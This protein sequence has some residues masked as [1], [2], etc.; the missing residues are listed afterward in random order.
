MLCSVTLNLDSLCSVDIEGRERRE[1]GRSGGVE[2]GVAR[3]VRGGS[4]RQP[5]S[6]R[7]MDHHIFLKWSD[8]PPPY[9]MATVSNTHQKEVRMHRFSARFCWS[10]QPSLQLLGSW[11]S[12]AEATSCRS[13]VTQTAHIA[14]GTLYTSQQH[15]HVLT[16][17]LRVYSTRNHRILGT[18]V[19]PTRRRETVT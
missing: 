1:R 7:H 5:T 19:P 6:H 18:H 13:C 4:I 12:C 11:V 14:R 9:L 8:L 15:V 3:S 17:K 16:L 10:F 2:D